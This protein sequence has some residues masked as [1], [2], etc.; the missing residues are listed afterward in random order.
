MDL[1]R[2]IVDAIADK[3]GDDIVVLDLRT[4]SLI[5]DYFVISSADTDRQIHAITEEVL[6]RAKEH[7]IRP[8]HIEGEAD[9]GWVLMDYGGVIVHFFAP[10][11]RAYYALEELWKDASVVLRMQ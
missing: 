10:E 11:T 7:G 8:L 1:A 4:I 9:S 6:A 3:H 5:A 2:L